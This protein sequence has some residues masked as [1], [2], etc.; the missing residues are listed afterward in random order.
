MFEV[1]WANNKKV[2]LFRIFVYK[3]CLI[4]IAI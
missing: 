3:F 2:K 1:I 4:N